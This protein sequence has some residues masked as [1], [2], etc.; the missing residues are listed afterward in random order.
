MIKNLTRNSSVPF[1]PNEVITNISSYVITREQSETLKFGLTHSICPLK[2]NQSDVFACFELIHRTMSKNLIDSS[3]EGK[4]V[5]DLSH[6]AHTYVSAHKPTPVD[7]KKHRI[8]KSLKN[9]KN[10]VI[11]KPDKGNVVVVMNRTDY[12]SSLNRILSDSTKFKPIREDPTTLREGRLQRY[13]RQ[14][15]KDGHLDEEIYKTM[16]PSGSQP[17]RIYGLP[18]LHK[19]RDDRGIPPFR[20]IVSSIGTYNY[21][22]AKYLSKLLAPHIPNEHCVLDSFTFVQEM[23]TLS[24]FGKYMVSFDVESLFT[25]LPLEECI[26]LA[27]DYISK[28]LQN[29]RLIGMSSLRF[30]RLPQHRCISVQQ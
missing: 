20:A 17:A 18:K 5:A 24:P 29:L 8:L 26:K 3:H 7:L 2:I 22:L 30:F 4:I 19:A 11:L 16:Y 15:K 9:N 28:A 10:I 27:V 25:S 13:L 14:L 6:L 23:Q 21:Q 12:N 1:E